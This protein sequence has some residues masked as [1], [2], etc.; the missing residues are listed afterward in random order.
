MEWQKNIKRRIRFFQ[1]TEYVLKESELLNLKIY[2]TDY[3]KK[4][5]VWKYF[6]LKEMFIDQLS[7][8]NMIYYEKK[9]MDFIKEDDNQNILIVMEDL[10]Y[11]FFISQY[12]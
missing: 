9:P 8:I 1:N 11:Y 6:F 5:K 10:I 4:I 7:N 12:K 2:D 3:R